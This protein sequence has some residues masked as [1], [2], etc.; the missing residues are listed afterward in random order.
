MNLENQEIFIGPDHPDV[1]EKLKPYIQQFIDAIEKRDERIAELTNP[2]DDESL[3]SLAKE[4]I[5]DEYFAV[6]ETAYLREVQDDPNDDTTIHAELGLPS[7]YSGYYTYSKT[8]DCK[9]LTAEVT[10]RNQKLQE[11]VVTITADATFQSGDSD[12]EETPAPY[13]ESRNVYCTIERD[14]L[15]GKLF[16]SNVEE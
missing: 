8:L 12:E 9:I 4:Y 5:T 3:I 13:T 15:K 6:G 2:S 16:V 1:P 14:L 10:E 11:Y 7:D